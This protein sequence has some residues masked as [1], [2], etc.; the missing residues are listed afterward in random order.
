VKQTDCRILHRRSI[1]DTA[2]GYI[3]TYT[4]N[5]Q[6]LSEFLSTNSWHRFRSS[7]S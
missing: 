2:Q 6:I 7:W 5:T 3:S 4:Q 1:F